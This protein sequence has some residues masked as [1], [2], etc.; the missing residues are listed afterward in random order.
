MK[1]REEGRK[2][3]VL[4]YATDSF[5]AAMKGYEFERENLDCV[6][7]GS[8]GILM[9]AEDPGLELVDEWD[10]GRVT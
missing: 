10:D 3:L 6:G 9:M 5:K 2:N 8:R 4:Q 1:R 7:I